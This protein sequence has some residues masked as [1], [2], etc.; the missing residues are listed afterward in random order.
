MSALI[1]R[2]LAFLAF[3]CG[4]PL[5]ALFALF[6]WTN[7]PSKPGR[8]ERL[9]MKVFRYR[10]ITKVVDGKASLYLRRFY[11]TPRALPIRV[12]L[13]HIARSD[14]DR[15]LHD[16]PF[17]FSTTLLRGAYIEH[18]PGNDARLLYAGQSVF[19]PAEHL[20]R[21]EL[22]DPVWSLVILSKARRVWG[23]AMEGV[24]LNG[25][26][27]TAWTD[28]RTYLNEPDSPDSREDVVRKVS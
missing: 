6:V 8:F 19:N 18:L 2:V 9:M 13:H 22:L 15:D 7:D 14:D 5:A 23:F 21:L 3:V 25:E 16:H 10:D 28:W 27:V 20:H 26:K 24:D 4:R 11:L 17:D 12:F 1:L